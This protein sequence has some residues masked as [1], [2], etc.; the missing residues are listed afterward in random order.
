MV[1]EPQN[2][3][4][5]EFCFLIF[6]AN[7]LSPA[8]I[9]N[10]FSSTTG[11]PEDRSKSKDSPSPIPFASITLAM[12]ICTNFLFFSLS[13]SSKSSSSFP[14][15]VGKGSTRGKTF[16]SILLLRNPS[17]PDVTSISSNKVLT[18]SKVFPTPECFSISPSQ[19]LRSHRSNLSCAVFCS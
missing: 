11:I 19:Q 14:F 2:S 5:W 4:G 6:S 16:S 1:S 3:C 13:G 9:L 12:P 15:K 7:R 8:Y 10:F 18:A 17:L